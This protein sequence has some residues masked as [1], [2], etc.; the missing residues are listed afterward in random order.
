MQAVLLF[1]GLCFSQG[2][3]AT[4]S[5]TGALCKDPFEA[6]IT[7]LQTATITETAA[8][9]AENVD[10][11]PA[12]SQVPAEAKLVKHVAYYFLQETPEIQ[13]AKQTVH[14]WFD[15]INAWFRN[16]S[17]SRSGWADLFAPDIVLE[18]PVGTPP[19]K[20]KEAVVRFFS[21]DV[22]ATAGYKTKQD[23]M[24][25]QPANVSSD[26]KQVAVFFEY[27]DSDK[28]Y[29]FFTL[30]RDAQIQSLRSF[31]DGDPE[32]A[33]YKRTQAGMLKLLAA[34]NN[35]SGTTAFDTMLSPEIE[36]EDPAGSGQMER[37]AFVDTLA[38]AA[39]TSTST[40]RN[41]VV[42]ADGE[43]VGL[44]WDTSDGTVGLIH[45]H[46]WQ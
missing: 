38:N 22:A 21:Q 3:T 34:M 28:A 37:Q 4:D 35:K 20:G 17:T 31:Q 43:S 46:K 11:R 27:G 18:D 9:T 1:L 33:T 25:T 19:V 2:A 32:S 5:C 29:K 8:R 13:R 40:F 42:S 15:A 26:G 41:V 36:V 44:L 45:E 39:R 12:F 6:G 10:S 14:T 24:R 30:N 16:T 23:M 7:L